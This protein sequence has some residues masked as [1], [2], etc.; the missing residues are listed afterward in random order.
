MRDI[1][2]KKRSLDWKNSVP[3]KKRPLFMDCSPPYSPTD[4][5]TDFN[6]DS[7]KHEKEDPCHDDIDAKPTTSELES[8]NSSRNKSHWDLNTTVSDWGEPLADKGMY[9]A[10]NLKHIESIEDIDVKS[11]EC[12]KLQHSLFPATP[13]RNLCVTEKSSP[14]KSCKTL[15][16]EAYKVD[17]G[18]LT[19]ENVENRDEK[20]EKS[21]LCDFT[22]HENQTSGMENIIIGSIPCDLQLRIPNTDGPNCIIDE[23]VESL[24]V[25]TKI[26][27]MSA[28]VITAKDEETSQALTCTSIL[29]S[30]LVSLSPKENS[31][32]SLGNIISDFLPCDSQL[33]IPNTDDLNCKIEEHVESMSVSAEK[34]TEICQV[35]TGSSNLNSDS[36]LVVGDFT[37]DVFDLDSSVRK[38][39]SSSNSGFCDDEIED[40]EVRDL[41]M[42]NASFSNVNTCLVQDESVTESCLEKE[43]LGYFSDHCAK[44]VICETFNENHTEMSMKKISNECNSALTAVEPTL[45]SGSNES[46]SRVEKKFSS[47][48]IKGREYL[49]IR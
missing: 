31:T 45:N 16:S 29:D 22:P 34:D 48:R 40:G 32:S 4:R 43:K 39:V 38:I 19:M 15:K 25:S 44:D 41:G 12:L 5:T 6:L 14:R 36:L 26:E 33:R 11:H 17:G 35:L 3:L 24:S 37:D 47:S 28:S 1:P 2:L 18:R 27:S 13:L 46:S 10:E 49:E 30:S 42:K 21:K 7:A 20:I 23:R 8:F 9:Y